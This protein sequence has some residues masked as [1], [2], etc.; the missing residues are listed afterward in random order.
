MVSAFTEHALSHSQ[1]LLPCSLS[2]L[3]GSVPLPVYRTLV[4]LSP[5]M[6][7][8]AIEDENS[9]V[10]ENKLRSKYTWF[11][12]LREKAA[13]G[14]GSPSEELLSQSMLASQDADSSFLT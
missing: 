14:R 9:N 6:S 7:G 13:L 8:S 11:N 1:D 10:E 5:S 2:S 12:S 4:S 3:Q